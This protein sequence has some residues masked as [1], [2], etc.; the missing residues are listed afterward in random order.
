MLPLRSIRSFFTLTVV[1]TPKGFVLH[2]ALLRQAF[3]HCAI[4]VTA[5]LRGGPGSVSVPMWRVN[6]SVPLRVDAL[7]SHYLTNKLMRHKPLPN[8]RTFDLTAIRQ[9]DIIWYYLH[10]RKGTEVPQLSQC[11]GYVIY[12]LL[13][14]SPLT[15]FKITQSGR[16]CDLHVLATPSAFVLSQDQTLQFLSFAC[17]VLKP[18]KKAFEKG[19]TLTSVHENVE[20]SAETE[21]NTPKIGSRMPYF[22][23]RSTRL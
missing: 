9:K 8:Q 22:R 3:A 11:S 7:V 19:S 6:L 10:F 5:A 18:H 4:F 15:S 17:A 23:F 2:T 1:Y 14:L 20:C 13:T 12:A 21:Q 16:S